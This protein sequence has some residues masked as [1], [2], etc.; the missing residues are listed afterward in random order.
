MR[1]AGLRTYAALRSTQLHC[2]RVYLPDQCR[3][4]A[5]IDSYAFAQRNGSRQLE[6][7]ENPINDLVVGALNIN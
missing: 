5:L 7:C 1:V 3:K 2:R 4:P 6:V